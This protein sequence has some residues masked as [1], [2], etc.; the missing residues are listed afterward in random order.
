MIRTCWMNRMI[1]AGLDGK[2]RGQRAEDRKAGW[3]DE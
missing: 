2:K 1:P 3:M